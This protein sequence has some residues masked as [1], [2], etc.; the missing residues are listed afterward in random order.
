MIHHVI[1][2][3]VNTWKFSASQ[4]L[5]F[6]IIRLQESC[7]GDLAIKICSV[8]GKDIS[9]II[10]VYQASTNKVSCIWRPIFVCCLFSLFHFCFA[11][12]VSNS[13][14]Q[15]CSTKYFN[16]VQCSPRTNTAYCVKVITNWYRYRVIVSI[17]VSLF[18]QS[19][20]VREREVQ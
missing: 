14:C 13:Y 9:I 6:S 3:A 1:I 17:V 11:F 5:N 19:Y 16:T 4:S 8:Y 10:P 20:K 2:V 18:L 12:V 15:N 7:L